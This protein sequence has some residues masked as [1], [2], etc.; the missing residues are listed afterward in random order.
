MIRRP[1]FRDSGGTKLLFFSE[2]ILMAGC[3]YA[4]GRVDLDT[5]PTL[6]FLYEGGVER[7]AFA[8]LTIVAAMYFHH[9]YSDVRVRSRVLLLQKLCEVFGIALVAQSLVIYVKPDW[10]LPR[11]L[12]V[13][14]AM[15]SLLA[16]FIWRLF[17]SSF[18]LNIVRRQRMVFVGHNNTIRE[19]AQEIAHS[20]GRGYEVLGFFDEGG[21][22]SEAGKW[23]GPFSDM[24]TMVRKAQPDRIV[25]GLED[26]TIQTPIPELLDL[27][28]ERFAIEEACQTY[29]A[30]HQRL[31]TKDLDEG[32][33]VFSR[34]LIPTGSQLSVQKAID[35]ALA[36]ILL[37]LSIPLMLLVAMLLR[38]QSKGSVVVSYPRVGYQGKEF[39][40]YRFRKSPSLGSLYRR[41]HLDAMPELINVL[42][43]EMALVGP[44]AEAASLREWRMLEMPLWDYRCNVRPGMTG[45]TQ[46]NLLPVDQ[47]QNPLLVLEYDLYYI[48]HMSQTFN[49]YI[50]MTTLKNRLIWADQQP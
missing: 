44:R 18:V 24:A 21:T 2:L 29:E 8:G 45:W 9:L 13:Y 28:Y 36:L 43:G 48:K 3:F 15:F 12:M 32:N 41:L 25:V 40:L 14:G 46:V 30:I 1:R 11:W 5:D 6:Y 20:P 33:L 27:H 50:L 34:D 23:L 19:I 39:Q 42:R 4:A 31:C 7:V 37:A 17:Y 49:L 38:L 47:E 26:R 35:R 16:I 10:I 22:D